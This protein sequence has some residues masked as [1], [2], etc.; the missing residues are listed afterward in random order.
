MPG[1]KVKCVLRDWGG[2]CAAWRV[3][4][5]RGSLGSCLII[6]PEDQEQNIKRRIQQAP[7]SSLTE[8]SAR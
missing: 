3:P 4:Q 7:G 2:S 5:N 6:L 8:H 1:G